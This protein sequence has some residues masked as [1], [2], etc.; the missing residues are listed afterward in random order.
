M[1]TALGRDERIGFS[2][3]YNRETKCNRRIRRDRVRC[4]MSWIVGDL[5][6]EGRGQIWITYQS[7]PPAW[8]F[9]YR[10]KSR[11][12]YCESV[13]GSPEDCTKVIRVH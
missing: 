9:S 5:Y 10:V 1:R 13:D 11:N 2:A 3:G 6:Y 7:D 4:K 12:A 8:N